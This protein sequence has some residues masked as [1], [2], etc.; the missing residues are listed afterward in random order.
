MRALVAKAYGNVEELA[1]AEMPEPSVGP[2]D[3]KIRVHAASINPLDW[4]LL[5]GYGRRTSM[6]LRF[7]AI[8]GR[9]ASGEVLEV[10][11]DVKSLRAGGA[12]VSAG[13]GSRSF[14]TSASGCHRESAAAAL[15]VFE[16]RVDHH[17]LMRDSI[18]PS[19]DRTFIAEQRRFLTQ[20]CASAN[21]LTHRKAWR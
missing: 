18:L 12:H 11:S 2:S 9:D 17:L 5:S 14:S 13:A 7:P 8:L 3:V 4:K 19:N 10:G 15:A 6:E 21:E 1:V 16:G 20:L